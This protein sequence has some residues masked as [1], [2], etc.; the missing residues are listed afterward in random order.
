[1]PGISGLELVRQIGDSEPDLPC[2]VITGYGGAEAS[3]DALKAGAYWYLEKSLDG[4]GLDVLKRL[5]RQAIEH[6]R[7]KAENRRLQRELEGRYGFANVVGDSEALQSV[8]RV[9]ERVAAS[10]S[11]VLVTG[12]S[13]TGKELAARAVHYNSDRRDRP[14]VTVNCGAIP[15]EL[16]ESELFGHVQGAFTGATQSRVGRFS[17]ADSAARSSS[18]RSGT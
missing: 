3:V 5:A 10:D 15:E 8:L 11:T 1:M 6:G 16:L 4:G 18:T 13:G 14:F 17:L 7:L 9:I 12:E 2:I